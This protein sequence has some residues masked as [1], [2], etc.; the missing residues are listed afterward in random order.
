MSGD[1]RKSLIKC[2]L[3]V[4][5]YFSQE[6]EEKLSHEVLNLKQELS[7]VSHNCFFSCSAPLGGFARQVNIH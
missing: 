1:R 2:I 7:K 6:R 3:D 5:Q 4:A